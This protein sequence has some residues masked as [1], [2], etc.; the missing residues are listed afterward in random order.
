MFAPF[1]ETPYQDADVIRLLMELRGS[2]VS[3]TRVL[4]AMESTPRDLFVE[5]SFLDKAFDD[6]ALPIACGQTISQP[7]IVAWMTAALDVG[8][9]M[10]VLEI[11][12][13]SGYQTA[14]LSKLSRWVYSIERH[15]E[16]LSE[17]ETRFSFLGMHN[18]TTYCTDGSRGWPHAAPYDRIIVTA[19]AREVPKR[20]LDQLAEGGVMVIPVGSAES[21]QLLLRIEKT[22][23][24]IHTRHLMPVRFVPLVE[25]H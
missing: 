15:R 16:L 5:D 25:E 14:I 6:V 1:M 2:G 7:S 18:I 19:A 4:S 24:G 11:G 8:P 13:G 17:A 12:T 10:R 22:A 23:E 9:R 20:L 21:D 3:D